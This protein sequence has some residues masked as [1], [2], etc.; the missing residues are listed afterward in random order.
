MLELG[1]TGWR[2]LA[3]RE[4]ACAEVA[5]Q[6][7]AEGELAAQAEPIQ[8]A[9][10]ADGYR[11]EPLVIALRSTWCLAATLPIDRPQDL[12]NRQ[13]MA[14]R[15]EEWIPWG[16]EEFVADFVGSG[17]TALAVAVECDPLAMLLARLDE[18][19]VATGGIVPA[20]LLAAAA[21]LES[22]ERPTEHMLLLA[23][24]D[25][26]DLVRIVDDQPT[27]W[28][29]LPA[30]SA[31]LG[32]ELTQLALET[33][34]PLHVI[35]YGGEQENHQELRRLDAVACVTTPD[36]SV[37]ALAIGAADKIIRG[38]IEAF[39][40]LVRGPFGRR[41]KNS[42]LR[43]YAAALQAGAAI[44][45]L[46]T[47][48]VLSYRGQASE[49]LAE[50]AAARQADVFREVFPNSKVPVGVRSRLESELTKLQG[51]QG[52]DAALPESKSAITLLH[53][54]L[55]S[56]PTDRRFRLLEIRIEQGRLYLDGEV[57]AHS[58]AEAIALRLRAK[59]LEVSS[60][61]TQRID[62]QRVSL[63]ITGSLALAS[64]SPE[65]TVR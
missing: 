33:G 10:A 29:W 47:T 43:R 59:G 19:G 34:Q 9:L 6:G 49:R 7:F 18:T 44:L 35:G 31:A 32:Q 3:R 38:G 1:P 55:S 12:R 14:Y 60:P 4:D 8:S 52:S 21:H 48:A 15:L 2:L 37:D 16:A 50:L 57:R 40:D 39:V 58:D 62:N 42:A 51:L 46:T 30:G 56:L 41:R 22:E 27:R 11:G 45:L 36:A 26:C 65:G 25:G 61:R 17:G 28:S 64:Q 20:A 63:R 23:T 53:R 13:T 24:H 5:A 54:L